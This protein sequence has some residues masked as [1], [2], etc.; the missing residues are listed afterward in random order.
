MI[1][2]GYGQSLKQN[3]STRWKNT[4][5]E[6]RIYKAAYDR[7]NRQF[8][9]LPDTMV[10]IK[11]GYTFETMGELCAFIVRE[12]GLNPNEPRKWFI[13]TYLSNGSL[14]PYD[15]NHKFISPNLLCLRS[16]DGES[17]FD[18]MFEYI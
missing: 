5:S 13:S 8:I 17:I 9:S 3:I 1:T 4:S 11:S 16:S 6:I 14:Y 12:Y 7:K 18:F 10:K 15:H 2:I